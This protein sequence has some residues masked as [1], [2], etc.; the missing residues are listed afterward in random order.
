MWRTLKARLSSWSS[1]IIDDMMILQFW[2]VA[3][4]LWLIDI[5]KSFTTISGTAVP[6]ITMPHIIWKTRRIVDLQTGMLQQ[7]GTAAILA[8]ETSCCILIGLVVRIVWFECALS[9]PLSHLEYKYANGTYIRNRKQ[10][11]QTNCRWILRNLK[12]HV[13]QDSCQNISASQIS[14]NSIDVLP[15]ICLL[16]SALEHPLMEYS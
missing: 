3:H 1:S 4:K 6:E 13:D 11:Y 9:T 15:W 16:K 2:N 12:M 8:E 14:E 10:M 7:M 5:S